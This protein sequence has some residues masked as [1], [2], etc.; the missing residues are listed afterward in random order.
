MTDFNRFYDGIIKNLMNRILNS[1]STVKNLYKMNKYLDQLT[2]FDTNSPHLKYIYHKILTTHKHE[3]FKPF[4]EHGFHFWVP[5]YCC[6]MHKNSIIHYVEESLQTYMANKIPIDHYSIFRMIRNKVIDEKRILISYL[7]NNMYIG[8]LLHVIDITPNVFNL[9]FTYPSY[10][11]NHCAEHFFK[12]YIQKNYYSKL[13]LDIIK[14]FTKYDFFTQNITISGHNLLYYISDSANWTKLTVRIIKFLLKQNQTFG[15]S[16]V[17]NCLR[18]KKFKMI[19][20]IFKN[21]SNLIIL[22]NKILNFYFKQKYYNHKIT[23]MMLH[24]INFAVNPDIILNMIVSTPLKHQ[25]NYLKKLSMYTICTPDHLISAIVVGNL[26]CV[27][28]LISVQNVIPIFDQ[29]S[30]CLHQ[31]HYNDPKYINAILTLLIKY[32]MHVGGGS[33]YTLRPGSKQN[34]LNSLKV[35]KYMYNCYYDIF[36]LGVT[37]NKISDQMFIWILNQNDHKSIHFINQFLKKWT[38]IPSRYIS[39]LIKYSNKN[40]KFLLKQNECELNSKTLVDS[41]CMANLYFTKLHFKD[42]YIGLDDI[43]DSFMT[44]VTTSLQKTHSHKYITLILDEVRRLL[45]KKNSSPKEMS[46]YYKV[47]ESLFDI[48]VRSTFIYKNIIRIMQYMHKHDAPISSSIMKT[49]FRSSGRLKNDNFSKILIYYLRMGGDPNCFVSYMKGSDYH[50]V[51][52][53]NAVCFDIDHIGVTDI[54]HLFIKCGVNVYP[55]ILCEVIQTFGGVILAKHFDKNFKFNLCIYYQPIYVNYELTSILHQATE[56]TNFNELHSS[57]LSKCNISQ[58]LTPI[59]D[60]GITPLNS[61]MNLM[62]VLG[63]QSV[64]HEHN[65]SII[66]ILMHTMNSHQL[67][68]TFHRAYNSQYVLFEECGG[69]K[70]LFLFLKKGFDPFQ[71]KKVYFED[72]NLYN[73]FIEY[74]ELVRG[75]LFGRV[76]PNLLTKHFVNSYLFDQNLVKLI[77]TYIINLCA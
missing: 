25:L 17:I 54:M 2:N 63:E 6:N 38:K 49:L 21:Y 27:K 47:I 33:I 53:L 10:R 50:N 29:L 22:D 62:Y 58:Y 40:C 32:G 34:E 11:T 76:V 46:N 45:D 56:S 77:S 1:S 44:T 74:H 15:S 68:P 20:Y 67:S 60:C 41:L 5:V 18:A 73:S 4:I 8:S 69:N 30:S 57:I 64:L 7:N 66:D 55:Q 12:I 71:I 65:S 9:I 43:G 3:W 70:I 19:K 13:N 52:L 39:M 72:I 48:N 28:Y 37:N 14:L 75:C 16:F 24:K 42:G 59:K 23:T 51:C 61:L 31:I 35:H 26:A 36:V